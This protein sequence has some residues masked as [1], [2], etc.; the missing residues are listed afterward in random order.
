MLTLNHQKLIR[1]LDTNI[2][3]QQYGTVNLTVIVKNGVPVIESAKLVKMR[4]K[5]YK[6]DN[7]THK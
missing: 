7:V 6:L 5:K 1:F 3:K 2:V 4:R